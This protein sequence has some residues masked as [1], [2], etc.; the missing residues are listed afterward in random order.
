MPFTQHWLADFQRLA[1][2]GFGTGI[3]AQTLIEEAQIVQAGGV[4]GIFFAKNP[5]V[6]VRPLTGLLYRFTILPL[7]VK[8]NCRLVY[9]QRDR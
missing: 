2:E 3:V 1:I 6:D 8:S 7:A 4:I 5:P 9:P